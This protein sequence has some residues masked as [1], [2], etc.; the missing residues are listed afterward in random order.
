[1]ATLRA[2]MGAHTAA[3]SSSARQAAIVGTGS[4][5]PEA[6]LDN[7]QLEAMVETSD[8][9]ILERT[10]IRERRRAGSG[11][12]TSMMGAEAGRRAIAA[13][14]SPPI[15]VLIVATFT[16]DTP[17]PSAACL[18]QRRLGLAGI[19]A[20]DVNAA[21]AGYVYSLAMARALIQAGTA[22]TVL[23]VAAESMTSVVDYSDR[24]TCV[25]FGDG[26]GATVVGSVDGG[27]ITAIN[28]GADGS[29]ADLIYYGPKMPEGDGPDGIRM[30]GK[31]TFRTAVERMTGVATQLCTDSGWSA[32]D[33]DLFVPHQ[34]N[35]RI[36]EA[37][38]KRLD[39]PMEK[40]MVTLDLFGNTSASSVP[41][42]LAA[43][44]ATG[45]LHQGDKVVCAAFGAGSTWG[46]VAMTWQSPPAR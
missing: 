38:A 16:P 14:G 5:L 25:L 12:T 40:V 1:M 46:G 13:A 30:Y 7:A 35:L 17:T 27:G 39:V 32:S 34:A 10:G 3:I 4:F 37:T 2:H 22:E 42:A 20:F 31:G 41:I 19:P 18:V 29:E 23:I 21:C 44:E 26:A 45:R 36:I 43:A 33:I 6:V 11:Q 9:W 24:A 15:D 28:W 8:A